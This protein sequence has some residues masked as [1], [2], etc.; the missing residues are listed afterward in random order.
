MSKHNL[1]V[2]AVVTV[3]FLSGLVWAGT[4]PRP[5]II[6]MFTSEHCGP[7]RTAKQV[8]Q[9]RAKELQGI[10]I[11]Y[12]DRDRDAEVFAKYDVRLTPTFFVGTKDGVV[13]LQTHNV[14][15]AIAQAKGLRQ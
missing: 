9:N 11:I 2:T 5:P 1:F 10:E 6:A 12:F 13:V 8:L 4:K 15:D 3:L 14:W 7:C